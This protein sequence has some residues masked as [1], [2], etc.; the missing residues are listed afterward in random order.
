MKDITWSRKDLK[1]A[2]ILISPDFSFVF[3]YIDALI[4][5]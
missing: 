1:I 4:H 2:G 3:I 5:L